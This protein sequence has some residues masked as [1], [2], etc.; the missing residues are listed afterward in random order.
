M[1]AVGTTVNVAVTS[2][3]PFGVNTWAYL[4]GGGYF[5]VT[6]VPAGHVTLSNLGFAANAAPGMTVSSG[7]LV[8]PTGDG[9]DVDVF[10]VRRYGAVPND[11]GIG[12]QAALTAAIAFGGGTIFVPGI[13]WTWRTNVSA[14]PG[15]FGRGITLMGDPGGG[16]IITLALNATNDNAL[17]LGNIFNA[18]IEIRNFTILGTGNTVTIDCATVFNI[19]GDICIIERVQMYG[20]LSGTGTLGIISLNGHNIVRDCAFHACGSTQAVSGVALFT[21]DTRVDHCTF[22]DVGSFSIPGG[23]TFTPSVIQGTAWIVLR[24]F[25][26]ATIADTVIDEIQHAGV[27]ISPANG[28]SGAVTLDGCFI[29]ISSPLGLPQGSTASLVVQSFGVQKVVFRD[30]NCNEAGQGRVLFN[31]TNTDS[32]VLEDCATSFQTGQQT[33]TGTINGFTGADVGTIRIL[34]C[35]DPIILNTA[36]GAPSRITIEQGGLGYALAPSLAAPGLLEF[37]MRADVG[38]TFASLATIIGAGAT[39]APV[40]AG[41]HLDVEADG[42]TFSIA[43]TGAENNQA[44]FFTTI[45]TSG[46]NAFLQATNA[47]GQTQLTAFASDQRSSGTILGSSSA[48]VLASLGL[49]AG[50]FTAATVNAYQDQSGK[51]DPNRNLVSVNQP[52]T[53][54]GSVAAFGNRATLSFGA[55]ADLTSSGWG[56]AQPYTVIAIARQIT[57]GTT[58]LADGLTANHNALIGVTGENALTLNAGTAQNFPIPDTTQPQLLI[59]E[60]NGALSTISANSD[61]VQQAQNVGANAIN[62]L[63]LGNTG[64]GGTAGGWEIAE[65]VILSGTPTLLTRELAAQYAERYYGIVTVQSQAPTPAQSGTVAGQ[66]NTQV[67]FDIFATTTNAGAST[68]DTGYAPPNGHAAKIDGGYSLTDRTAHTAHSGNLAA[69]LEQY[70]ATVTIAGQSFGGAIGDAG[71]NTSVPSFSI[72]GGTLHV[73]FTPPAA[74]TGTIEWLMNITITEN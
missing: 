61:V 17:L 72:S 68:I 9:T 67:A 21:G 54:N 25:G 13:Q 49:T 63:T 20:V 56:L 35:P 7:T 31:V 32:V 12:I 69:I 26:A 42:Y 40:V 28:K 74:Y 15:L 24:D 8:T 18:P 41:D 64:G 51:T 38:K 66:L 73:T 36:A 22:E 30:C 46:A 50:P 5:Q 48:D 44:T 71:L 6:A 43:F 11:V 1:P 23:G 34:D 19:A 3:S 52:A 47:G 60:F 65:Y 70:A 62:G 53:Y 10:D 59:C 55:N 16:T 58:V 29:N 39:Y 33:I 27:L 14:L 37:W 45:N 4:V 2:N 57:N